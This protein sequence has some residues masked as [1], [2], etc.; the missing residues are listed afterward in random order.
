MFIRFAVTRIDEESNQPQG[1]FT[2]A[3]EL[4]DAGDLSPVEE[5]RLIEILRWFEENL[6]SPNRFFE[7][8]RAIFWFKAEAAENVERMWEVVQTLRQ[9]DYYVE[10]YK[11]RRLANIVFEDA[12][13]VAAYPSPRDDRITVQ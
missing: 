12:A 5:A 4:L 13:Q 3:Y 1:I 7:A 2:A 10:V 8:R 6:P 9:H 11:C